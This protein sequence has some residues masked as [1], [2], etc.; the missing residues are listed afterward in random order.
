MTGQLVAAMG[1]PLTRRIVAAM[2]PEPTSELV[3]VSTRA[4]ECRESLEGALL[5]NGNES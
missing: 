3:G 4:R 5:V 1:F 2:G